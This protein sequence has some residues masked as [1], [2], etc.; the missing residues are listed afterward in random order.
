LYLAT[1]LAILPVSDET[2]IKSIGI[3]RVAATAAEAIVS[4]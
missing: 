2:I 4:I 1:N 3:V